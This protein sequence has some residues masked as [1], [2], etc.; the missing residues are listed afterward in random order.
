[1]ELE[2]EGDLDEEDLEE[3]E[4]DDFDE[5]DLKELEEVDEISS[6]DQDE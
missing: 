3:L 5:E 1:M 2:E 4:E 6:E